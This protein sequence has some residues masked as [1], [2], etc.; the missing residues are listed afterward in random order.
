MK[1]NFDK[2]FP[3]LLK[4]EGGYS[5]NPADHGGPTKYGITIKDVRSYVKKNATAEDVK[6]LTVDQAKTIYKQRYWDAVD[7]DNL[8]SGVD[9]TCFDYGVNSGPARPKAALAKAKGKSV[10]DTIN[11]INDERL[12]FLRRI[13]KNPGQ[14]QF[15]NGWTNRVARVRSKSLQL[16]KDI[17]S[18]PV[19]GLAAAGVAGAATVNQHFWSVHPV[20]S[21]IAL[22]GIAAVIGYVVHAVSNAGN[23]HA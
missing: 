21:G 1:S 7:G 19:T 5:N 15:L 10:V 4:D 14:G 8:P 2:I 3:D 9:Y 23:P 12:A 17:T 11:Y 18:G 22:V 6:A 20:W 13:A 16:A